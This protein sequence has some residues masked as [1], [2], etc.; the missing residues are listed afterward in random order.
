LENAAGERGCT[1]FLLMGDT[2]VG[3]I[4]IEIS[5]SAANQEGRNARNN[6]CPDFYGLCKHA[7]VSMAY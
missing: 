6:I 3:H 1:A 7:G 2:A 4:I 5:H